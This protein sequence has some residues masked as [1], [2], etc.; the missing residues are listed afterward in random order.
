MPRRWPSQ[1]SPGVTAGPMPRRWSSPS[2]PRA[3]VGLPLLPQTTPNLGRPHHAAR[4]SPRSEE[5]GSR[6]SPRRLQLLGQ[7]R[8][9]GRA[10]VALGPDISARSPSRRA[11]PHSPGKP[12]RLPRPGREPGVEA[13]RARPLRKPDLPRRPRRPQWPGRRPIS[14]RLSGAVRATLR[15]R[16]GAAGRGGLGGHPGGD[17]CGGDSEAALASPDGHPA[18]PP[19]ACCAAR[20]SGRSGG[21]CPAQA[22]AEAGAAAAA[23]PLPP[24]RSDAQV[25][26]PLD[27][28]SDN[29]PGRGSEATGVPPW[30]PPLRYV[31]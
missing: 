4:A 3:L 30:T 22:T 11:E 5:T 19:G 2:S 15:G 31:I 26:L 17:P 24:L 1:V 20:A 23:S 9:R 25:A 16:R 29:A 10:G 27:V 13:P 28:S 12:C 14:G 7:E 18:E 6:R 8:S 21:G